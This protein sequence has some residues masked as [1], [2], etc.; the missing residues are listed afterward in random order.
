MNNDRIL[1]RFGSLYG[2]SDAMQA[3]FQSI[4]K[5]AA[6]SATVLLLGESGTGKELVAQA[7][8]QHSDRAQ[9]SFIPVNCGAI[10]AQLIEAALFGHEKGSFT[11]ATR[12]H[13]GY[14]EQASGGTLFLDEITEMPPDMQVRL[15]RVLESGSFQRVGGSEDVR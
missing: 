6:T 4:D 11:G 3:L 13:Q 10:P 1:K 8:H 15:L 7:I 14:F 9:H 5:V 2:A 12:Q